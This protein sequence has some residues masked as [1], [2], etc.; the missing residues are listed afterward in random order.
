MPN[1]SEEAHYDSKTR[2]GPW[3]FLCETHFKQYGVPP[4]TKLE[5]RVKIAYESDKIPVVN[6]PL[7][8][9][10]IIDVP[11]PHC[12]ESRAVE[13]D[14]NYTVTCESCDNKFRVVSP[15]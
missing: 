13:P 1:C 8:L 7:T 11:C 9:D 15:I 5:K 3:G 14:A 12:G 4:S 6:L 10:S 2:M